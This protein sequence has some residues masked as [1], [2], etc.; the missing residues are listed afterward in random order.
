[1]K[2]K[3]SVALLLMAAGG[4]ALA[5]IPSVRNAAWQQLR[6]IAAP[7]FAQGD[8]TDARFDD[9][10]ADMVERLPPQARAERAL[11]LV[12][13]RSLGAA[14]YVTANA[15]S[16]SGAIEA[17]PQL[18]SLVR[19]ALDAPRIETRMAA[20][21]VFLAAY[22]LEKSVAQAD[23]LHARWTRN[24]A[25]NGP[26]AMWSLA[27]LAARGVDRERTYHALR[28]ALDESD[29]SLRRAAVD[30]F[31][32]MGGAETIDPLLSVAASDPSPI[33]RERAFCAL[34][35][36]GTLLMAER[37]QAIPGLLHIADVSSSDAQNRA[38][39]Y[40]ALTEISGLYD[41]PA[42]TAVWRERLD[43]VGLL[44]AQ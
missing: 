9:F 28:A 18:Q 23:Q 39:S 26:W 13:N 17:T 37:Y 5:T 15:A 16:W 10:Y 1:M 20:F 19:A 27:M 34:A 25:Q 24:P 41:V 21:E 35:S 29:V 2:P 4:G 31:A 7:L 3:L 33:V 36:S 42:D 12:L 6:S 32:R 22:G 38:W 40:Q 11:E 14:E 8:A 43:A 30:A 44:T